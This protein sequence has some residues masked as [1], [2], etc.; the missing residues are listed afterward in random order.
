[1]RNYAARER[2]ERLRAEAAPRMRELERQSALEQSAGL[3]RIERGAAAFRVTFPHAADRWRDTKPLIAEVKSIPGRKYDPFGKSWT[4][5]VEAAGT[6]EAL[7]EQYGATIEALAVEAGFSPDAAA[8]I[9][10]LEAELAQ[11]DLYIAGLEAENAELRE[12]AA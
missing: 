3:V 9:A 10:A 5:P 4:V 7:A 6:I 11:R 1:M 12:R 2:A 8:R